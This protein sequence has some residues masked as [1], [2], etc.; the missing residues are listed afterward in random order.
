[1]IEK[2]NQY[3][4]KKVNSSYSQEELTILVNK[5]YQQQKSRQDH[6]GFLIEDDFKS[7][8]NNFTSNLSED[9]RRDFENLSLPRKGLFNTLFYSI[10]SLHQL[11]NKNKKTDEGK[12]FLVRFHILNEIQK[13]LFKISLDKTKLELFKFS[14]TDIAKE[15][16]VDKKTL[17]K[18]LELI[19]LKE[20]YIG[21]KQ[22]SFNEYSEIFRKLFTESNED[23]DL[24][25]KFDEYNIRLEDKKTLS[26]KDI[27]RLGF[28][29]DKSPNGIDYERADEIIGYN[30]EF[31]FYSEHDKYPYSIAI[32]LINYLKE[33]NE[34]T[35][36]KSI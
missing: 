4:F 36:H 22:L 9:Q 17:A 16:E 13:E 21:R 11:V 5:L 24:K 34:Q 18:W 14:Q 33:K 25:N 1:M 8:V 15:F 31:N 12:V 29:I 10:S 35:K 7:F 23:F 27:I 30:N 26:K 6:D 19:G 32:K 2:L 28:F 20:K 3:L